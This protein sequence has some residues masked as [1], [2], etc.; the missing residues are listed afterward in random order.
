M[1]EP[2]EIAQDQL[3]A[4]ALAGLQRLRVETSDKVEKPRFK[5]EEEQKE[6][7]KPA[8]QQQRPTPSDGEEHLID[9]VA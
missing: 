1:F 8:P 7:K 2:S 9:T 4:Q 6:R 3:A 5:R